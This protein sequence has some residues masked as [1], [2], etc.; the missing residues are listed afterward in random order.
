MEIKN[1]LTGGK[2]MA[3]CKKCDRLTGDWS[4]G[5]CDKHYAEHK[6]SVETGLSMDDL[7]DGIDLE[8]FINEDGQ[9][10]YDGISAW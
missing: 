8:D 1:K 5:L 9:L 10:D 4:T 2:K 6:L 7:P 3:G